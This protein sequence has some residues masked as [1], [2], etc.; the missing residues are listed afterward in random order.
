MLRRGY[1]H[2]VAVAALYTLAV[3]LLT[4][5]SASR[6]T[7]VLQVT[8]VP[9]RSEVI[10]EGPAGVGRIKLWVPEGI[11]SDTGFS[12]IYPV[13]GPWVS[14]GRTLIQ[15]V[16]ASG[17]MGP[18]NYRLLDDQTIEFVGFR[19]PRDMPVR[20]TTKVTPAEH[21]VRFSIELTNLGTQPILKAGAA[22]CIRFLDADWW[23]DE[24]TYVFSGGRVKSLAQ[25]GRNT[26]GPGPFE[27]YLLEGET[28]K[29]AFYRGF[30]GFNQARLLHPVM[31]SENPSAS[32]CVGVQADRACFLHSNQSNPC[33]DLMLA[34]G[35]VPPGKTAR[36]GGEIWIRP[37]NA[38]AVMLQQ[39]GQRT[40]TQ[41]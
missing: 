19:L 12:S 16:E 17:N 39:V 22:V 28:C 7:P 1:G 30:W 9:E 15:Q 4:A 27:A 33:T 31:V 34:F 5:C 26:P 2:A 21:D 36:A 14:K 11:A 6:C 18:G 41:P 38:S 40:G 20:W 32:L 24:T 8:P 35:D 3:V 37:G 23:S 10:I 13:G 25:L 29:N